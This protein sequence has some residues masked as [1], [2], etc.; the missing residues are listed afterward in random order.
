MKRTLTVAAAFTSLLVSPLPGA[1]D[2]AAAP[3]SGTEGDISLTVHVHSSQFQSTLFGT[4]PAP[5]PLT[6]GSFSYSSVSCRQPAPFNDVALS[7]DPDYPGLSDPASVRH[8]LE[9]T[10]TEVDSSG[11]TGTLEGTLTTIVCE[12]NRR[13]IST[14]EAEFEQ[15]SDNE[16]QFTG[17]FQITGGTGNFSDLTGSGTIT[18]SLTCLPGTLAAQG[19]EDCTDLGVFSDAVATLEGTFADPT[20]PS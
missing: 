19:A 20:A 10:V 14:F 15:V 11:Q 2:A 5:V 4:E 17:T 13:I 16:V 8:L 1:L 6:T 3:G 9:I 12:G 7:F 18:G